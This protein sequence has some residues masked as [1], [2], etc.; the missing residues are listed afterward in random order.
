M[1]ASWIVTLFAA[2]EI[3]ASIVTYV[4]V[5][6]FLQCETSPAIATCYCGLLF[7][8]WVL[9]SFF[10]RKVRQIG[11]FRRQIQWLELAI[12]A[13]LMAL[14]F[15]FVGGTSLPGIGH[16]FRMIFSFFSPQTSI[17]LCL[18]LLSLLTAWH[19]LSARM[20]YERMLR[21]HLQRL[22]NGPKIVASQT[23]VVLTYGVLIMFVGALQVLYRRIPRSWTEGCFLVSGIF[24]IFMCYHLFVLRRPHVNDRRQRGSAMEAVRAEIL[25]IDRIRQKP[26]WLCV[27]VS[28]FL[29]LLP[30]SLMFYSRVL[31]LLAPKTDG[32]LGCTIQEVGFA[33]GTVG[34]IA[35]SVGLLL[36]RLQALPAPSPVGN[37]HHQRE[38]N[39]GKSIRTQSGNDVAQ[40]PSLGGGWGR[41]LLLGLSP[42][43]YLM[44]SYEP[45][46]SLMWL[47]MATFLAQ[48]FFGYG[49][50]GIIPFVRYISGD[51]YRNTINYL[52]IPL[53]ATA[54]LIPLSLSGWLVG[55]LGF[56]Q[57][58]LLDVLTAPLAWLYLM[59]IIKY[60]IHKS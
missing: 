29:L 14:A 18:F 48:F 2:E 36:G 57:Y 56:R 3:P 34:V 39:G 32:G 58:F 8:P 46:Q 4:A 13:V 43:V 33:Q 41:Y 1:R 15:S 53:V 60:V 20:Y 23:A 22:Y 59:I 49:L 47:S 19:E 50:T 7:L 21:P 25:V 35:F 9:K 17:F 54:F 51:R 27:V 40:A 52:Y 5:L 31:F 45:P 24:L 6:M 28:L 16:P 30:Q 55:E 44:M 12:V 11:N 37:V 26:Y 10:R 42:V 38:G